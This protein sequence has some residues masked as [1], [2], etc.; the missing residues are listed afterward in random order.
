MAPALPTAH[1]SEAEVPHTD[2]SNDDEPLETLDQ[3]VPLKWRIV[4][5]PPTAHTSDAEVPQ[6]ALRVWVVPL[7]TVDH[8]V[9][10]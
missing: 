2:W 3:A 7:A 1:T 5:L 6:T 4:P 10:L 8:V 9:P